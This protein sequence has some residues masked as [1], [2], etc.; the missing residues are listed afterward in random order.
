MIPYIE[1]EHK[2]KSYFPQNRKTSIDKL[3]INLLLLLVSKSFVIFLR[4]L[5]YKISERL[6]FSIK[7]CVFLSKNIDKVSIPMP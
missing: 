6:T 5:D 3:F 4:I 7:L 1:I 2:C